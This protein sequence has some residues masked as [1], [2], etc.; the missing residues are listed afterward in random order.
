MAKVNFGKSYKFI[1]SPLKVCGVFKI[2]RNFFHLLYKGI[3]IGGEIN[4]I[5]VK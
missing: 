1:S 2:I 4:I 3:V 5:D